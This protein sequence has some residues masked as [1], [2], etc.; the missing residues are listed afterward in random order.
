M[1]TLIPDFQGKWENLQ[2][3]INERPEVISHNLETVKRLTRQVRVQA[4]YERSLDVLKRIQIQAY[5]PNQAS[6]WAGRNNR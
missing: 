2:M 6:C 1:E 4:K 3:V 5:M